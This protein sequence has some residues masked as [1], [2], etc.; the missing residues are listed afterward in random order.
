M[1]GTISSGLI[2]APDGRGYMLAKPAGSKPTKAGRPTKATAPQRDAL[3]FQGLGDNLSRYV[4]GMRF[5]KPQI[6]AAFS[7]KETSK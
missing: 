1:V 7:R 3:A 2:E 5:V 6:P 4:A